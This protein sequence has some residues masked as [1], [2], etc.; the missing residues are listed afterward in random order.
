VVSVILAL[1]IVV[2]T[3]CAAV[4]RYRRKAAKRELDSTIGIAFLNLPEADANAAT[5]TQGKAP[6]STNTDSEQHQDDTP[7]TSTGTAARAEV[8][9]SLGRSDMSA[10]MFKDM[11][12]ILGLTAEEHLY[13]DSH[14]V[15][16]IGSDPIGS[17]GFGQV[18]KGN[19]FTHTPVAVKLPFAEGCD[20]TIFNEVRLFRRI[21]HPN[22][23]LF[24]G[25][26][27]LH[28]KSLALILEWIDGGD[29]HSFVSCRRQ[30]GSF[31]KDIH[32][33]APFADCERN[34]P[35]ECKVLHDVAL[36]MQY[37]QMHDILHLDLHPRNVLVQIGRPVLAKISDFGLSKLDN[38]DAC[39]HQVGTQGY[40]A[41]EVRQEKPFGKAAD[42]FSYGCVVAF[43]LAFEDVLKDA[44]AANNALETLLREKRD[45]VAPALK[46][47]RTAI[48]CVKVDPS[49]RPTFNDILQDV[50]GESHNLNGQ[51]PT[52]LKTASSTTKT[53]L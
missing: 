16:I 52:E 39:W 24:H 41:P 35:P 44:H 1:V 33:S 8:S 27:Y 37:I 46:Y 47:V 4:R 13:L 19:L 49:L 40:M 26:T 45:I 7:I 36:G 32:E 3:C 28:V 17:G 20:S 12:T 42:I 43:A 9:Q 15:E 2:L 10:A 6:G 29:F 50:R 30:D 34:L 48:C 38:K 51:K 11:G 23:V 14:A 5:S 53:S 22:V 18:Y 21:R 25:V 31:E